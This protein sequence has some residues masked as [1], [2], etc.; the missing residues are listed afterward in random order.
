MD[1]QIK[2][3]EKSNFKGE[4]NRCEKNSGKI[5]LKLISGER[6]IITCREFDCKELRR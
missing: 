5:D 3:C 4:I 6:E 2:E 1:R